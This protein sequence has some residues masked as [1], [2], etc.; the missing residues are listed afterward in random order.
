MAAGTSVPVRP[1]RNSSNML[2]T[3]IRMIRPGPNLYVWTRRAIVEGSDITPDL[4]E[5][6]CGVLRHR[7]GLAA[8]PL[9][10]GDPALLVATQSAVSSIRLA[11]DDWEIELRDVGEPSRRIALADPEGSELL[12]PLIERALEARL[13]RDTDLWRLDSPRIWYEPE[14]FRTD[15]GI[16]AFRRYEVSSIV[17]E[18][19]GLG[20]AVDIGTAF[21]SVEDLTF[22]F[23]FDVPDQERD[24]RGQRFTELTRR[25]EGQKGTLMYDTGRART[26][27]YFESAPSG[28]TCATTGKIRV[29]GETYDSLLGYYTVKHPDLPVNADTPAV[30]VSFRNLDR[31]QWVAASRLRVRV[32]NDDVPARLS[33]VD[34]IAPPERRSLLSTFWER[35][36]PHPLGKVAPGMMEGFWRPPSERIVRLTLPS[37]LFRDRHRLCPPETMTAKAYRQHYRQRGSD[38]EKAGCYSAPPAMTRTLYCAYPEHVDEAI[39]QRLI[40]DVADAI[41]SWTEVS[42]VPSLV[43]YRD[44]E[45]AATQLRGL[46]QAGV[47]VFILNDEPHAYHDASFQLP[48]WRIKRV[49]ERVLLQHHRYVIDGAWDKRARSMN[50]QLGESRWR[51]FVTLNALDVLQLLDAIPFRTE[52][53]GSYEA[54]LAIDVGHDRRHFAL[55]LLIARAPGK[56][57]DFR[58]VS[59]VAVKT[60]HQHEM[61]NPVI[62]RDHIVNLVEVALRRPCDQLDSILIFR[63][64]RLGAKEI[65]GVEEA[66]ASLVQAGKFAPTARVDL[67]EVHKDTLK[68]VRLWEVFPDERVENPLEGTS[69]RL[70]QHTVVLCSTG[71]ATLTQGTAEPLLFVANG[72][73]SSVLDAAR[74]FFAGAQLNW[75]SPTVAQRLHIALKRTDD[76]LK[77][78]AAQEIRKLR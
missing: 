77:A 44:V 51:N 76:E 74:G 55:S 26:K 38:L 37:L 41:S 50:L 23:A 39:A 42:M 1:G 52:L 32:M 10:N 57:P 15:D 2:E 31:P 14:P 3:N 65:N 6:A 75:S 12:P 29:R 33:S 49:T 63:D 66:I 24:R 35:L 53:E 64:G 56:Q 4:L 5:R 67:V 30:R 62:L 13:E 47:V 46:H 61:I 20:I 78:R 69:V 70:N 36:G 17:V 25:Q 43:P 40:L 48:D 60:D 22:F 28:V 11:T 71:A 73:C 68:G 7:Y 19:E 18:G 9:R 58:L 27:C 21:F 8:V 54:Q 72:H 34:K 16:A 59:H 45:S